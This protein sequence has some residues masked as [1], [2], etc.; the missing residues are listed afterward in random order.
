MPQPDS[1]R[2][3]AV[4][5]LHNEALAV[6]GPILL[7]GQVAVVTGARGLG[8]AFA[9]ALAS[10][11]A[12]VAIL[13]R[14]AADLAQTAAHIRDSGGRAREFQVDITDTA[15]VRDAFAEAERS[16]GPVDLLVNNAG[17]I[18][19]IGPFWEADE[20]DWWRTVDVNF[21]GAML[22]ARAVLPGMVARRCGRIVNVVT[23]AA[24]LAYLS[25]YIA[26]KSALVRL[27][28]CLAAETRAHGIAVFSISPGTVRTSMAEQGLNSPEAREWIPW[29]RRIFDERIDV[30]PERPA[31]LVLSLA[32]GQF[33][34]LSGLYLSVFDDL[35]AIAGEIERVRSEQLHSMRVRPLAVSPVPSTVASIR[36][37]A[38]R[39]KS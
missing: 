36:E 25:A 18:G 39:G 12:S 5:F 11:G 4:C 22:C 16:L 1:D 21:R 13:A 8:R 17:T 37:E 15:A 29:F 14:S 33:D 35:R 9:Q 20:N 2:S 27:S 26:S 19:P 34:A 32:S 38:E 3:D 24:P 6:G 28:E 7:E 10:A 31:N 30:P 23:A